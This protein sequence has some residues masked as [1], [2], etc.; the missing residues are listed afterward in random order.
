MMFAILPV[1]DDFCRDD[2]EWY[3]DLEQAYD[4]A[5]DWSVDLNGTVVNIYEE[6]QGNLRPLTSVFA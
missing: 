6:Y 4:S 3:T 5:F 1:S 2:A